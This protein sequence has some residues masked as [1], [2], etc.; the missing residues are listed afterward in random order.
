MK[1]LSRKQRAWGAG[2][3]AV[4]LIGLIL[5]LTQVHWS[6]EEIA[7]FIVQ[8][9]P[10]SIV[11]YVAV[12]IAFNVAAPLSASPIMLLGFSLYGQWA[13][14]F[15]AMGNIAAMGIN[16]WIARRFGRRFLEWLI[17]ADDMQ[18]IDKVARNHGLA[19]LFIIRMFVSGLNDI[20]SYA[21][22]LTPMKFRSYMAVSVVASIPPIL[23]FVYLSNL[24]ENPIQLLIL[25]LLVGGAF[26]VI[27]MGVR[28]LAR[29]VGWNWGGFEVLRNQ[30]TQDEFFESSNEPERR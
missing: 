23:L 1:H 17:G 28:L 14:W 7:A 15:F 9:G 6:E 8:F 2:I 24:F 3:I 16:F 27:Y 20:A 4:I 5:Y 21:F 19:T 30:N 26:T 29:R 25:Q 18:Q 12:V 11:A 10:L 13:V 22:G